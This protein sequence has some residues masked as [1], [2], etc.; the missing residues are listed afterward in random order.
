MHFFTITTLTLVGCC[1]AG[2]TIRDETNVGNDTAGACH[3]E[4][5][6]QKVDHSGKENG[7]FTQRYSLNTDYYEPGGPVFWMQGSEGADLG[8]ITDYQALAWAQEFKGAAVVLEHRYFGVSK[9][10]GATDPAEQ[11]EEFQFLTLDN[12]MEDAVAFVDSLRAN[13]TGGRE[14]KVIINGCSY[15]GWL[16]TLFRQNRPNTF[17]GAVSS[18]NPVEGWL[19]SEDKGRNYD[20]NNWLNNVY[21]QESFEAWSNIRTAYDA[22]K[23]RVESGD[24]STLQTDFNTCD[25]PTAETAPLLY[26]YGGSIH[27]LAAQ[28]NKKAVG[29]NPTPFPLQ[30]ALDIAVSEPDPIQLLNRTIWSWVEHLDIP[31][32][33]LEALGFSAAIVPA[34][35]GPSFDY[36]TSIKGTF[37]MQAGAG[38]YGNDTFF[39]FGPFDSTE[40]KVQ[41]CKDAYGLTPSPADEMRVEYKYTRADLRNS[42]RI[43]WIGHEYDGTTAYAAR[44]PGVT[45]P[46]LSPDIDVSRFLFVPEGSHC[47]ERSY[48]REDDKP[49]IKRVRAQTVEVIRGWLESA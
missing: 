12:V 1:W 9:P 40:V 27:G 26:Y 11:P 7:T 8:C 33:G 24:F 35:E 38:G 13:L 45:L 23:D 20:Y 28:Y 47:E 37:C 17:W 22:L 41:T 43:L 42:T 5:F 2:L 25:T 48:P 29:V 21:Q 10:F 32:L 46:S 19:T 16:T 34:I 44:E 18:S 14:S 30:T 4:Y 49:S 39:T 6:N 36:I 15:P 3:Y 31:C